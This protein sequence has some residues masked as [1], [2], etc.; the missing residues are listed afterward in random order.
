LLGG[1]CT[2]EQQ[3]PIFRHAQVNISRRIKTWVLGVGVHYL[4]GARGAVEQQS[5]GP[6]G[7]RGKDTR[8]A[9]GELEGPCGTRRRPPPPDNLP[10][11]SPLPPS[12]PTLL[13]A[14]IVSSIWVISLAW[15][16]SES[17]AADVS[18]RAGGSDDGAV[19]NRRNCKRKPTRQNPRGLNPNSGAHSVLEFGPAWICTRRVYIEQG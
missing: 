12:P 5:S 14:A 7:R 16:L 1:H 18:C 8:R 3:E 10:P 13:P 15:L 6:R 9:P 17:R 11:P 4:S 2:P 19:G